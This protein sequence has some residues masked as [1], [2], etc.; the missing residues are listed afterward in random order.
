MICENCGLKVSPYDLDRVETPGGRVRLACPICGS[1]DNLEWITCPQDRI[2]VNR[3]T[4]R[5]DDLA[6]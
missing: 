3:S 1:V 5:M 4:V 2:K 6:T